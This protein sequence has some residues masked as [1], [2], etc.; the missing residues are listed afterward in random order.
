MSGQLF[1]DHTTLGVGGPARGWEVFADEQEL[2]RRAR[3]LWAQEED[4]LVLGG[5]SNLVVADE[6]FDGT[7]LQLATAGVQR[8][9]SRPGVAR[10]RVAAGMEWDALVSR[11]AQEGL[12]GIEALSGIPGSVGAAPVQNIGAYGQEIAQSLAAIEFLEHDSGELL[13]LGAP[14][15]GLG[16]RS[17]ALKE[18]RRGIVV[19]VELF[20]EEYGGSGPAL[21]R[22][23]AYAQLAAALDVPLGAR[24][25]IGQLRE[26][27]LGLRR[28]KG[29]LLDP[30]DPDTRS[31]GSFFTNPIVRESF[32]RT[33]PAEAPRWPVDEMTEEA[34]VTPLSDLAA[35]EPLRLPRRVPSEHQVKLS[36]AWLIEHAGIGRGY[37]LPGSRAA[38]SGKHTLA[39]TNT[40]GATAEEVAQLARFIVGRV[41]SEFG[42]ILRPEPLLLGIEL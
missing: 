26:A 35:G 11:C 7:V 8:L 41:Q 37:R 9:D 42:V 33:L 18:G 24:V 16:Y 32:A 12:A 28:G 4:W 23:V 22:P 34:V 36:A 17:S 21:S 6:G 20:L 3:Q 2:I 25:P 14:E 30:A 15:L 10:L 1:R 27:V 39:I 31:A 38:V 29:M 40:G 19:A 13:R 5:G